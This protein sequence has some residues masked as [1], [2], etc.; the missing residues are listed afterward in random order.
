MRQLNMHLRGP[1]FCPED[2]ERHWVFDSFLGTEIHL[3]QLFDPCNA[4]F[5]KAYHKC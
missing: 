1:S 2:Q 4:K 3:T 5:W